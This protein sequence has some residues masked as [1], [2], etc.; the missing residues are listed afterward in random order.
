MSDADG[1]FVRAL[2][3]IGG[4]ER[5]LL[6]GELW[7]RGPS[8]ELLRAFVRELFGEG[9][10]E[11]GT[12]DGFGL[13]FL[14]CRPESL[15]REGRPALRALLQDVRRRLRG[16]CGAAA[17]VGALVLSGA[18]GE[19]GQLLPALLELLRGV[20]GP[21]QRI[22]AAVYRPGEPRTVLE[23]KSAACRA[24]RAAGAAEESRIPT[25]LHCFPWRQRTR[26]RNHQ[27]KAANH[28]SKGSTA[29]LQE[30][31]ALTSM[32]HSMEPVQQDQ[33]ATAGEEL[34]TKM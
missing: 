7:E 28:N 5:V 33:K 11:G 30:G 16:G 10:E 17:L 8:R 22:Q 26:R 31:T 15:R 13:L 23:L 2:A 25:I 20:F 32:N 12:G 21:E 24:L 4:R 34:N 27:D 18:T 9:G 1:E 19:E 6:V 14:L 29:N 3:R